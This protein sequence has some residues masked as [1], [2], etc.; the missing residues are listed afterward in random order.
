MSSF[1]LIKSLILMRPGRFLL[2][3][4]V[5]LLAG[6]V[7]LFGLSLLLPAVGLVLG[8]RSDAAGL[9]G[10]PEHLLEQTGLT[11]SLPALLALVVTAFALK[12][13]TLFFAMRYAS[14]TTAL[15]ASQLR[16]RLLNALLAARWSHFLMRSTG[17]LSQVMGVSA[18]LGASAYMA[19]CRMLAAA[20]QML[21]Y[22]VFAF[23]LSLP[24]S[25]AA[26]GIAL[27]MMALLHPLVNRSRRANAQAAKA[28]HALSGYIVD[29]IQSLKSLKAMGVEDRLAPEMERN[30]DALKNESVRAEVHRTAVRVA[31]E[32]LQVVAA[33][34]WLY[35]AITWW[36]LA[37][38]TVAVTL[39]LFL[40]ITNRAG[41]IQSMFQ[42]IV[43]REEYWKNISSAIKEAELDCERTSSGT[44]VDLQRAIEFE[45]VEFQHGNTPLLVNVD[46]GIPAG[47]ITAL[48]GPSGVGK[49]TLL[50]LV[51]GLIVPNKGAVRVDGIDLAELDLR[52]WRRQIGY[53]PQ[54]PVLLHDTL[55]R[56][57]T[58][59]QHG[60][61]AA[62]AAEA[63]HLAGIESFIRECPDGM[64]TIVGERGGRL[65]GGQR[66]RIA[67]ARALARRPRLLLLDE[68]TSALD[69][70]AEAEL[71]TVL[72][73]LPWPT[74][75]VAVSHREPFAAAADMV[76][77]V[78][79]SGVRRRPV[80]R[81]ESIHA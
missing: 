77:D 3:L 67:I 56:N 18:E 10:F 19:I 23:T 37:F 28:F 45:R 14:H 9:S 46:L 5:L 71:M 6:L 42:E 69:V 65:S 36:D 63:A 15:V 26:V 1:E 80:A 57:I 66:Q 78:T 54:D 4:L 75:I 50:D 73:R 17:R 51:A 70:Q 25:L 59:D 47:K 43:G 13:V 81:P 76:Y 48:M 52:A 64:N 79:A 16:I 27:L 34:I 32:P 44:V 22:G 11:I 58:L 49:T 30:I 20:I 7:E 31:R 40:Q 62:E 60:V 35:L 68:A 41:A 12:S 24:A 38:E 74:T 33:A 2:T 29:G 55:L 72:R 8:S 53:V 61:G 39:L 21:V